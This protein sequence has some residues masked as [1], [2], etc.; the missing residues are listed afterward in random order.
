MPPIM[1]DN[2]CD[3][4]YLFVRGKAERGEVSISTGVPRS[5]AGRW[6]MAL[7]TLYCNTT[8]EF[9]M[10][11]EEIMFLMCAREEHEADYKHVRDRIHREFHIHTDYTK[12]LF[13]QLP[14]A[15]LLVK[16]NKDGSFAKT[17]RGKFTPQEYVDAMNEQLRSNYEYVFHGSGIHLIFDKNRPRMLSL[18]WNYTYYQFKKVFFLPIFGTKS[19]RLLGMPDLGTLQ[20][21]NMVNGLTSNKN[22]LLKNN[23]FPR[24]DT[25]LM[26]ECNLCEHNGV[27]TN[28]LHKCKTHNDGHVLRVLAKNWDSVVIDY[29][30]HQLTYVPIQAAAFTRVT[31]NITSAESRM[32]FV[33][34]GSVNAVLH[35]RPR[36]T[37]ETGETPEGR[38]KARSDPLLTL[39]LSEDY[40]TKIEPDVLEVD[41]TDKP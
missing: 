40:K 31:L 30:K 18:N 26:V 38:R 34:N 10:E 35:L 12:G 37:C 23:I 7:E 9:E 17:P 36:M 2:N 32:P 8:N 29:N 21:S 11:A 15:C 27:A 22:I 5:L 24:P 20:F 39:S 6:E 28:L 41:F 14:F 1:G 19:R 25:P 13:E 33:I 16:K 3:D 4:F